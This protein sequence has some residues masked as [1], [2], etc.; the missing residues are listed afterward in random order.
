MSDLH[1]TVLIVDDNEALADAYSDCLSNQY[2]TCVAYSGSEAVERMSDDVAVI[3]LD[4]RMPE[5]TGDEVLSIVKENYDCRVI[6]LTAV[7]AGPDILSL[8]FDEYLLKPLN[9]DA[10]VEAVE[11]QLALADA[12]ETAS[13]FV[14]VSS[15]LAALTRESWGG[16][17]QDERIEQLKQ[18]KQALESELDGEFLPSGTPR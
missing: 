5:M 4:R 3:I 10:L 9:R 14:A 6:I 13:E 17:I 7:D 1:P 18:H 8:P 2:D 12:D 15:T 16:Q 11:R